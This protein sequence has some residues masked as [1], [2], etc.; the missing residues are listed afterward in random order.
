MSKT[1]ARVRRLRW[2][3]VLAVVT[4][5]AALLAAAMAGGIVQLVRDRSE[6]PTPAPS[7]ANPAPELAGEVGPATNA[8]GGGGL[9]IVDKGFTQIRA[10]SVTV[11]L[12]AVLENTSGR[13]AYRTRIAFR[14][15][16][17]KKRPVTASNGSR[18]S[19]IEI[20]VIFPSQRIVAANRA[21][22]NEDVSGLPLTVAGF[23]IDLGSTRWL[24][25]EAVTRSIARVSVEGQRTERSNAVSTGGGVTYTIR[26]GYCYAVPLRGVAMVFRNSAGTILGGDFDHNTMDAQCQPG[27]SR[28]SAGA[29]QSMPETIDLSKTEVSPYCDISRPPLAPSESDAPIN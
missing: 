25:T 7:C 13:V 28:G 12:G 9:R 14:V 10:S 16:D 3:K 29:D 23:E 26:S 15:F 22:V 20:P 27:I 19:R 5:A 24:P 18:F 17:Q 6:P 2:L 21:Y 11:S 1:D 4:P 8:P